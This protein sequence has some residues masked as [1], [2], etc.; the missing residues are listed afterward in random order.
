LT[1]AIGTGTLIGAIA[2]WGLFGPVSRE[3]RPGV[4]AVPEQ[5][6]GVDVAKKLE[7]EGY[8]RNAGAFRMLLWVFARDKEI[9]SGGFRLDPAMSAR[10]VMKKVTAEPQLVW[11]TTSG[12][13]RKE[14][15][16]GMIG[17]KL[18]W[19]GEQ[20][21]VWNAVYNDEKPEWIEGVYFPDTYLLPKDEPVEAVAR[22]FIDN[23]NAK[24]SP[25]MGEFVKQNIKWTT[26]LKIASLVHASHGN[27][28]SPRSVSSV[29]LFRR[30]P[31]RRAPDGI[32]RIILPAGIRR[33]GFD[34]SLPS[35][36][37]RAGVFVASAFWIHPRFFPGDGVN[38]RDPVLV[39]YM[40]SHVAKQYW[41]D[42]AALPLS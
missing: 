4:F 27:G 6:A 17:P 3:S 39:S 30:R 25:L 32:V 26:G 34:R 29:S 33:D 42:T 20:L 38:V 2:W 35:S 1:N 21:A 8:I 41:Y 7:T 10:A 5:K 9:A 40:L 31:R 12:C 28:D 11:M 19:S 15:I 24:L 14:Q 16:G 23:F 22:R 36:R 18:E 13:L 37:R